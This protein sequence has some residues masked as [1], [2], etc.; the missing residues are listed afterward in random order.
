MSPCGP[1]GAHGFI[2]L[3]GHSGPGGFGGYLTKLQNKNCQQA[4]TTANGHIH[5]ISR[6]I[7]IHDISMTYIYKKNIPDISMTPG[8]SAIG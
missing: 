4:K 2:P 7:N 6:N 8:H 5:D 1:K 3:N